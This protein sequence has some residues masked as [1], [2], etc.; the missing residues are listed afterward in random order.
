MFYVYYSSSGGDESKQEQGKKKPVPLNYLEAS[1]PV[2][3]NLLLRACF[4]LFALWLF[5]R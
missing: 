5:K 1:N 3:Q 2:K 4:G